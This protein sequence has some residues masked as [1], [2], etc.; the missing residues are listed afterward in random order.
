M[1]RGDL[2]RKAE[3]IE[4]AI[5]AFAVVFVVGVIWIVAHFVVKFW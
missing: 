3:R 4:M 5:G 1:G 2:R